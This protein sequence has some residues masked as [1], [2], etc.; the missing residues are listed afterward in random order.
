DGVYGAVLL[1]REDDDWRY[2][3]TRWWT[4]SLEQGWLTPVEYFSPPYP[5]G[6]ML[7]GWSS[8]PAAVLL[9]HQRPELAPLGAFTATCLG[10]S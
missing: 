7:Q 1:E 5:P 10:A 8:L 2:A 6:G 4:Y 3:L 9:R